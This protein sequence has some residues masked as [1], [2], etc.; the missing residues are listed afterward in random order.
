MLEEI[1]FKFYNDIVLVTP[2][3]TAQL[4][5]NNSMLTR[6]VVKTHQNVLVFYKGDTRN[7]SSHFPQ[8]EFEGEETVDGGVEEYVF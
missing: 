2:I 4:R 1:G 8:L 6:K 5:A 7:I 3:G